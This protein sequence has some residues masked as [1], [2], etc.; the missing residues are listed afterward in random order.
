MPRCC[1]AAE[2]AA[3]FGRAA[4]SGLTITS[5]PLGC[6]AADYDNDEKPDVAISAAGGLT[7]FHNEGGGR[8]VNV[9]AKSGLP[10][11]PSAAGAQPLGLTWVDYDHDNDVDL[12]VPRGDAAAL[13]AAS[14][15]TA[16]GTGTAGAP[17]AAAAPGPQMWR[18][19]G[20]GTF[21]EVAAERGLAGAAGTVAAVGTRLQQRPRHR[22]RRDRRCASAR[23]DQ[24]A[25]RCVQGPRLVRA[26]AQSP[27]VGA[28]VIDFD[29]DGWMDLAF[30]HAGAPGLSLWRNV[31]G[32]RVEPVALPDLKIAER[33]GPGAHRLRQRRL[34]GPRRGRRRHSRR[35]RPGRAAQ[36][37]GALHRCDRGDR[38]GGAD[39]EGRARAC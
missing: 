32:K 35:S 2:P 30:T 38:G 6:A 15:A 23:L 24:P 18:N 17:P 16:G 7:L 19:N 3:R 26:A 34:G 27:T 13:G 28:V 21:A 5:Q 14:T 4:E 22:P 12:I 39:A 20:N 36:R 1:I 10:E 31:E 37:R 29:K 25:R 8:F 9:T 33:L 11:S